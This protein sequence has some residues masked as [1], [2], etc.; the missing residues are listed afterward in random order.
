MS[1]VVAGG[2]TAFPIIK[3]LIPAQ[4]RSA[5]FWWNLHENGE[6]DVRTKHVACPVLVGS[7][8]GEFIL[9]KLK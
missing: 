3:Q 6:G 4:K 2:G 9:V 8:W 5:V 1:D 7:K